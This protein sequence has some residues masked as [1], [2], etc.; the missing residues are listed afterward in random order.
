MIHAMPIPLADPLP[1]L[2]S[3]FLAETSQLPPLSATQIGLGLLMLGALLG[4]W[5]KISEAKAGVVQDVLAAMA[6]RDADQKKAGHPQPFVVATE[7]KFATVEEVEKIHN[8][9]IPRAT[10]TG[11]LHRIAEEIAKS[12]EEN[13]ELEKEMHKGHDA[14]RELIEKNFRSLDNKRSVSIGNL[15]T[16]L[17]EV[18]ERVSA[19]SAVCSANT[20]E[21]HAIA[22]RV[23]RLQ[24]VE[25]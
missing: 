13:G 23:D 7:T 22:A 15:H 24:R 9:V 18:R 14:L 4:I 8:E 21:L 10:L 1:F 11:D 12:R 20:Q 3:L 2:R 17:T 5:K 16:A 6:L 19:T 25:K